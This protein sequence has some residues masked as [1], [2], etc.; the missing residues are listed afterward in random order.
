MLSMSSSSV[1]TCPCSVRNSVNASAG[2]GPC[3]SDIPS[4]EVNVKRAAVG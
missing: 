4:S 1:W 2:L 3:T